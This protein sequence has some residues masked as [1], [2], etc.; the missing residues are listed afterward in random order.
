MDHAA[1]TQATRD[2]VAQ[3]YEKFRSGDL[4]GLGALLSDDVDWSIE[5]S[6]DHF[7]FGGQRHGR[8]AVI[9]SLQELVAT[10]EHLQYD[11]QFTIVDG[12]RACMV[13]RCQVR[14]KRTGNLSSADL[15]DLVKVEDGKVAWFR[16]FFDTLTATEQALGTKARFG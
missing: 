15:C 12:D 11:T 4:E 13:L 1:Q 6:Q 5:V 9:Q 8:A 10:L 16:E 3:L 2:V 7:P 14:D